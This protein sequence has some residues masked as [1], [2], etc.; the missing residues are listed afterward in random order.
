MLFSVRNPVVV[1]IGLYVMH[2]NHMQGKTTTPYTGEEK[3][4]T[5]RGVKKKFT[6]L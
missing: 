1:V 4:M 6:K 3:D 5:G 2:N